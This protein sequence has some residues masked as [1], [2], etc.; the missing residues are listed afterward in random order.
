MVIVDSYWKNKNIF[1]TGINGFIGSNLAKYLINNGANVYGLVRN[2]D[3]RT[4]IH[5]ENIV[6]EI[7]IID[8]NQ[9][10]A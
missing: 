7:I 10:S 3:N 4:L 5:Y 8:Q 9:I 2:E 1:I 6:K